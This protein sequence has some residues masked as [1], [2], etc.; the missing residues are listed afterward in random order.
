MENSIST[1]YK[2]PN[3]IEPWEKFGKLTVSIVVHDTP[4]SQLKQ[5]LNCVDHH[6]VSKI[7][8]IDNS[9]SDSLK[10]IVPLFNRTEY[11]HVSNDGFG[12]GHNIAIKKAMETDAKYHLVMNADVYWVEDVLTELITKLEE[13]DN[14]GLIAP[15]VFYPNGY[16]QYTCRM[17]P[18]PFILFAKR[19]LPHNL[20][21]KRLQ[22][23]LL[24]S[25]DHDYP[26]NVPYLLGSFLLFRIEAL[27]DVGLFDE[28]F[29]MYPEDIDITRRIHE[30]WIT[31]YYPKVSII[32]EHQ[33][34]SRKNLRMLKI[35]IINMIKYFNKWGWRK[36]QK[37]ILFNKKLEEAII[38]LHH[39]KIQ[40]GR[41]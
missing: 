15:K 37:R 16:L 2:D 10:N 19:F 1:K 36:D 3:Y 4:P 24:A 18:D 7:Y 35:H 14:I 38:K 6:L 9:N 13:D 32:H 28:R 34:A 5:A 26:L 31:L 33:A 20:I 17:L 22:R 12:A 39:S 29:F 25:H 27:K 23:Y 11:Y 40:Q 30:K 8:V 41:G 21:K